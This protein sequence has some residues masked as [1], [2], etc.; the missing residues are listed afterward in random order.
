VGSPTKVQFEVNS[1]KISAGSK[2]PSCGHFFD[3]DG[4]REIAMM[5]VVLIGQSL[6]TSA[7]FDLC[8]IMNY[9]TV[10]QKEKKI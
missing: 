1:E 9:Q 6:F 10:L 4:A 8:I 7:V 3:R 5:T 2:V